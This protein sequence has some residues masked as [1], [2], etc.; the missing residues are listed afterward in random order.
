MKEEVK[1]EEEKDDKKKKKEKVPVAAIW[2]LV[3]VGRCIG[4]SCMAALEFVW[5][6]G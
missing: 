6:G 1:E 5:C 2:K 3:S 4:T